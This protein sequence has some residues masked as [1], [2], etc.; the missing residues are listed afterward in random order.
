MTTVFDT[1][2]RIQHM[3][4]RYLDPKHPANAGK[5]TVEHLGAVEAVYRWT[6][7]LVGRARARIREKD[8][9]FIVMSDHGFKQFQR[10][11]NLNAW[12]RDE[13]YLVLKDGKRT[14]GDWFDGVDW[15][16]TKAFSMGLTGMFI[17]RKGREKKGIVEDGAELGSR[18]R[19]RP[20]CASST[21]ARGHPR[22]P[23]GVRHRGQLPWALPY[24]A[25]DLLIG[26]EAGYRHSWT[27]RRLH[28]RGRIQR[29]HQELERRPLHGPAHR[30]GDLLLQPQD[31]H[32][33]A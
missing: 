11:V 26:Y 3:F 2:D 12:L 13:G 4:F 10:G 33:G 30:A 15:T 23:R 19:S 32:R 14:G 21:G 7:D 25:P 22:H 1:T 8:T 24:E 16:K 20:S 6:D 17:N 5:D 31:Q 28:Q 18:P 9:V 27:A 29:Q